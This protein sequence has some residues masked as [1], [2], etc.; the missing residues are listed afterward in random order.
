[1]STRLMKM[2]PTPNAYGIDQAGRKDYPG[3]SRE[4]RG[5]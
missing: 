5:L 3:E 4:P 2:S 1:M